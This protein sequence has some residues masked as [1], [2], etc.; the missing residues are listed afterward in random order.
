VAVT[1]FIWDELSDNV[2]LETDETDALTARYTN[3]PEQF[4]KLLSQ[5]RIEEEKIVERFY[6][7]DGEQSTSALTD[8]IETVT[9]TFIYTAFGEEVARSGTTTNPFGYKGAVGYY[10]N[11][12]TDDIYVRARTYEPALGCWLSADP[13]GFI[14]GP[15]L[16]RAYFVPG[17]IDP[18]G[19]LTIT[20]VASDLGPGRCGPAITATYRY[21]LGFKAKSKGFIIQK[22]TVTCCCQ[23]QCCGRCTPQSYSYFEAF[24]VKMGADAPYH[25]EAVYEPATPLLDLAQSFDQG[26]KTKIYSQ[27][28]EAKFYYAK[29]HIPDPV[30]P[31]EPFAG[32]NVSV[33]QEVNSWG[34]SEK[35]YYPAGAGLG[36]LLDL[37]GYIFRDKCGTC[38][39][40]STGTEPYFWPLAHDG[41]A[42]ASRSF[43]AMFNCGCGQDIR[44]GF[45]SP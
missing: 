4:G 30:N 1:N 37:S 8:A 19:E 7:F 24:P 3:R 18:S 17:G 44:I 40:M 21:N 34:T 23:L 20:R 31:D 33:G 35:C 25:K 28:T 9:D 41:R 39:S 16:Y 12:D 38:A 6:H 5:Y 27:I 26:C 13:I 43:V 42:V 29:S 32:P 15:N 10:T 36:V 11:P 45:S 2:L 22:V 14:D